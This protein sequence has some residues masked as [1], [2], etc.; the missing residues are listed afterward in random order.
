MAM[1]SKYIVANKF[2][3]ISACFVHAYLGPEMIFFLKFW[4]PT[5]EKMIKTAALETTTFEAFLLLKCWCANI[6]QK[7]GKSFEYGPKQFNF[8]G[9]VLVFNEFLKVQKL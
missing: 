4:H 6:T 9:V 5:W 2:P 1:Y 7:L 3:D 8:F